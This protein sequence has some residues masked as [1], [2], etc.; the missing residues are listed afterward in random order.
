[1]ILVCN[2]SAAADRVLAGLRWTRKASFEERLARI[3]P[4]GPAHDPDALARSVAYRNA[5]ADVEACRSSSGARAARK[6]QARSM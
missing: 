1:M 3:Q 2:D 5:V 4:R 6:A